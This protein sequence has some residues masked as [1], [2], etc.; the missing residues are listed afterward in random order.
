M[1]LVVVFVTVLAEPTVIL[2]SL[3]TVTLNCPELGV[4]VVAVNAVAPLNTR[5]SVPD[6]V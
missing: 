1:S 6:P 3:V 4:P 2:V 5:I